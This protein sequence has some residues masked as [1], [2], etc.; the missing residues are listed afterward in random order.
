MGTESF[1]NQAHVLI[2][3]FTP[4]SEK[5]EVLTE[6][7]VL[8]DSAFYMCGTSLIYLK[9]WRVRCL[10]YHEMTVQLDGMED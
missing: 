8:L 2:M 10:E 7:K 6:F 4:G 9:T 5:K 1:D 3:R